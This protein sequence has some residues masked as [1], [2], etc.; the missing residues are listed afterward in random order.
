MSTGAFDPRVE[1]LIKES[2]QQIVNV[3][4]IHPDFDGPVSL[5]VSDIKFD[6]VDR[7]Y[8]RVSCTVTT[9]VP[10]TQAEIERLDPRTGVRIEV[11]CGYSNEAFEDIQMI[12][13]LGLRTVRV[14]RPANT[15][16]LE[17]RSDEDM[18]IDASP[19]A[20]A[21][22]SASSHALAVQALLN[23][24]I[25]PYP[26]FYSYFTGPSVSVDPVTDRWQT[27]MDLADRVGCQLYDDGLRNFIWEPIKSSVAAVPD[28]SLAV[29]ENGTV[30]N[31]ESAIDRSDWYN[32]V[33]LRYKWRNASD[34]DVVI[35]ATALVSTGAFSITGPSGKRILID[36]REIPTTQAEANA[37]AKAVLGRTLSRARSYSVTAIAA[38]WLR[39]GMT[40]LLTLPSQA[41]QKFLVSSV[42]FDPIAGTMDVT[43]AL[44]EVFVADT[45]GAAAPVTT[46]TPPA[47]PKT[48]DPPP[49]PVKKY[50]ST[51][52]ASG[53]RTF[54][55]SGSENTAAS[56]DIIQG[57]Y[58]GT[59][60]NQSAVV[61][62]TGANSA[63]GESGKTISQALSGAKISKV[64]VYL[65]CNH[66]YSYAGGDAR[67]GYYDGTSLPASFTGA[68]PYVTSAD[69][70]AGSGR[71]VNVTSAS[72]I[73]DL[74][75]GSARGITIG[76]G[77]GSSRN[78]YGKFNGASASS[79]KPVLRI[80]YSK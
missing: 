18:V 29:G 23:Q 55:G 4:A 22:V 60:G 76:P 6:F 24:A 77:V 70:K 20:K 71:W 52:V 72:F 68:K 67:I 16:T 48:E 40:V 58:S 38:Y 3:R 17:A 14:N 51:W 15:M 11:D 46:T 80:T 56:P 31:S 43:T 61:V 50:T 32:Y 65:Y 35:G 47:A 33:Y 1:A 49:P 39:P 63:G 19:A 10:A 13:D 62:F 8:P 36:E 79:G 53:S 7:R 28:L 34:V 2:H 75:D 25:S 45:A 30:L 73:R 37:A 78:Y 26:E 64:E 9:P 5:P 41:P 57:Y 44:P 42:S 21:S 69:W 74:L 12:L 54:K 66:F 27:I 59:N